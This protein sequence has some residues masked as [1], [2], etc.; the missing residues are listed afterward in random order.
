MLFSD[1]CENG[2]HGIRQVITTCEVGKNEKCPRCK[3]DYTIDLALRW[4]ASCAKEGCGT[5]G[6]EAVLCIVCA[7]GG[8]ADQVASYL[9]LIAHV[10]AYR[11]RVHAMR[12]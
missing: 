5:T 11:E 2:E 3:E 8:L 6:E 7:G 9:D 10:M 1:E 12:N 4:E